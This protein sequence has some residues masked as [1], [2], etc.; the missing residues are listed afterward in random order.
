[1]RLT[2]SGLT[3]C[4][5]PLTIH[6]SARKSFQIQIRPDKTV[7]ARAPVFLNEREVF[8]MIKEKTLWI[9]KTLA[10]MPAPLPPLEFKDGDSLT[11]RGTKITLNL[12]QTPGTK[13]SSVEL[14]GETLIV[15]TPFCER[16]TIISLLKAWMKEQAR[17]EIHSLIA[18]LIPLIKA[19]PHKITLRE[20]KTRWGSCSSRGN[21]S[22]NW[23]IIM[24]PPEVLRYLVIH[25]MAHLIHMNHSGRFWKLVAKLDPGFKSHKKWLKEK[26]HTLTNW[27]GSYNGSIL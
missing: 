7:V 22:F 10:A 2:S 14:S 25:E 24:A 26:G 19:A 3:I 5:Q 21:L 16:D 8:N 20:Q 23:K 12:V 27:T 6:F 4:G 1:M 9:E 11:Y 17:K 15:H 18:S 13:G